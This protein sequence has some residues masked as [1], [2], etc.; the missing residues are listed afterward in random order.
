MMAKE[1]QENLK[2]PILETQAARD[3]VKNEMEPWSRAMGDLHLINPKQ[4]EGN[5]LIEE[6][7]RLRKRLDALEAKT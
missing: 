2:G 1:M 6:I 4:L 3:L 5:W 7:V